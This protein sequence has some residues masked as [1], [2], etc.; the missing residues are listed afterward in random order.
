M[1]IDSVPDDVIE[2]LFDAIKKDDKLYV[3]LKQ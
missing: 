3:I 2:C 1:E